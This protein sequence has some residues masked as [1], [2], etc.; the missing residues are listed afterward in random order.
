MEKIEW[1]RVCPKCTEISDNYCD[2]I[3]MCDLCKIY[4]TREKDKSWL[5]DYNKA[6]EELASICR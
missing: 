2:K 1:N 6:V 5:D 3:C 4:W